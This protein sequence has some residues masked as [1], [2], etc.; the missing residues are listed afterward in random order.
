MEKPI[1]TFLVGVPA[2]GKT[3]WIT[4]ELFVKGTIPLPSI[5]STDEI[6]EGI[7]EDYGYTY[8]EIWKD[9]I[10]FAERV[11]FDT[12]KLEASYLNELVIDRTNLSVK[13]RKRIMDKLPGY[14]F[15][16]IVFPVPEAAEWLRR[17]ESRPGK[18]IPPS[19]LLDM[20]KNFVPPTYEEGF[21]K[22]TLNVD[23]DY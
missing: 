5:L 19:T 7:A 22:I 1:C 12:L 18:T 4:G 3:S 8:N 16:A 6:V 10:Q 2:S 21:T 20:V 17:L 23:G 11:F 14:E 15:H 9:A 13:S